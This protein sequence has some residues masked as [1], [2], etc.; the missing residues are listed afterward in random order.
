MVKEAVIGAIGRLG[1]QGMTRAG[2]VLV[3]NPMTT[4]TAAF[5]GMDLG[6]SMKKMNDLT[7]GARNMMNSKMT[8]PANM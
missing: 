7:S 2:K 3:K 1:L 6:G 4:A 8:A 5:A